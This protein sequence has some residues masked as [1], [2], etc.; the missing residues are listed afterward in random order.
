M[1][2]CIT[3]ELC[4]NKLAGEHTLMAS[5]DASVESP[6]AH[7]TQEADPSAMQGRRPWLR[8]RSRVTQAMGSEVQQC[9]RALP[10]QLTAL[11][12]SQHGKPGFAGLSCVPMIRPTPVTTLGDGDLAII[13]LLLGRDLSGDVCVCVPCSRWMGG[14]CFRERRCRSQATNARCCRRSSRRMTTI[15]TYFAWTRYWAC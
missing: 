8:R 13:G 15:S 7:I 5:G 2:G 11:F 14:M 10:C 9:S 12:K 6:E 1:F 3:L 4:N